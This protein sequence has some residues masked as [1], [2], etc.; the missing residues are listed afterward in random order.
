MTEFDAKLIDVLRQTNIIA[1]DELD[2]VATLAAEPESD[3]AE[4]LVQ[5]AL[6]NSDQLLWAKSKALEVP[7]VHVDPQAIDPKL[8]RS[9]PAHLLWQATVIPLLQ[10]DDALTVAMADPS[11]QKVID[12]LARISCRPVFPNLANPE[13][14]RVALQSILGA[15]GGAAEPVSEIRID[16]TA[17]GADDESGVA[18]IFFNIMQA[19]QKGAREV[20]FLPGSQGVQIFHRINHRLVFAETAPEDRTAA[21]M[22]R[23]ETL[24]GFE[25][26]SDQAW[27]VRSLDL[28][29]FQK[30]YRLEF[31]R[32]RVDASFRIKVKIFPAVSA[33]PA[34]PLLESND[35]AALRKII[36]D[37]R[38]VLI[39]GAPRI[40]PAM[41]FI[42]S[43]MDASAPQREVVYI[44]DPE[45]AIRPGLMRFDTAIL[46][47]AGQKLEDLLTTINPDV[48]IVNLHNGRRPILPLRWALSDHLLIVLLPVDSAGRGIEFLATCAEEPWLTA[49][50]L[51]GS[52]AFRVFPAYNQSD[53]AWTTPT[54][55]QLTLLTD[56]GMSVEGKT[57]PQAKP[58]AVPVGTACLYEL[59]LAD[60]KVKAT[61]R[62]S[63]DAD[64][65]QLN[66]S[67]FTYRP[68]LEKGLESKGTATICLSELLRFR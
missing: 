13:H 33:A 45:P 49:A 6:L 24:A 12:D 68:I 27:D 11:C 32:V 36:E 62:E 38:G 21:I 43:L 22:S 17:F 7:L 3:L 26:A 54:P 5:E 65:R 44:G 39:L 1:S 18:V 56:L 46:N 40:K 31:V 20:L 2:R 57:F 4:I 23:L 14:I 58:G 61:L 48:A 16:P 50:T 42:D 29:L 47:G 15:E 52:M 25:T 9:F 35:A 60:E 30:R 37:Q 53:C 59:I 41:E 64:P 8:V 55:A 66:R 19:V 34:L 28:K 67:A 63:G 51:A 10:F